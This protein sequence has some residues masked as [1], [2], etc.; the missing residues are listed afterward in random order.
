MKWRTLRIRVHPWDDEET[1]LAAI[2]EKTGVAPRFLHLEKKLESGN[3]T[4]EES[5]RVADESQKDETDMPETGDAV[6]MF[7]LAR[8]DGLNRESWQR[9]QARLLAAGHRDWAAMTWEEV[10]ARMRSEE[11][12]IDIR[13]EESR[14]RRRR[15]EELEE[16][17]S[18]EGTGAVVSGWKIEHHRLKMRVREERDLGQIFEEMEIPP[19]WVLAVFHQQF[20]RW[21]ERSVLLTKMRRDLLTRREVGVE[22]QDPQLT[23][24]SS[25]LLS[26]AREGGRGIYLFHPEL[27]SAAVVRSISSSGDNH[28][29]IEIEIDSQTL[30]EPMMTMLQIPMSR[31]MSREDVGMVGSFLI[32]DLFIEIP[33]LQDQI[34]NDPIL[35]EFF[36]VNELRRA[37]LE[38]SLPLSFTETTRSGLKIPTLKKPVD[39]MLRNLHRQTGFQ[40][41]FTLLQPI[42]EDR[43]QLFF[44][45]LQQIMGRFMEKRSRLLEEYVRYLPDL[46]VQMQKQQA[47]LIKNIKEDRPEY[48]DKYPGM[49]VRSF[50]SVICQKEH[51]PTILSAEEAARQPPERVLLFPPTPMGEFQP[52]YYY[53]PNDDYRHAGLKDMDLK[54]RNTMINLA[55]CCFNKTQDRAN[56]AKLTNIRLKSMGETEETTTPAAR[57]AKEEALRV[58]KDNI[59][60]GNLLIKYP[61]QLGELRAPSLRRLLLA[62]DPMGEYFRM[63][64]EQSPTSLLSCLL[65]HRR[66][67]GIH[68][69]FSVE[70]VRRRIAREKEYAAACLQ[71]NPGMNVEEIQRDMADPRIY[72]DPRRFYRAVELFFHV[73]LVVFFKPPEIQQEEAFL[74]EPFSARSHYA[75]R[76]SIPTLILLEHWGGKINILSRLPYPHCELLCFKSGVDA[77]LRT[78]F[79]SPFLF[80]LLEML[81]ISM[82]GL[83]RLRPLDRQQEWYLRHVVGQTPDPLGKIRILHLEVAPGRVA[84]A[85]IEPPLP[86]QDSIP[87]VATMTISEQGLPMNAEEIL[88][89]L[90]RFETWRGVDIPDSTQ[91]IVF[92]RVGAKDHVLTFPVML[93]APQ[94][95]AIRDR[96]PLLQDAIR[97]GT[98]GDLSSILMLDIPR[99]TQPTSTQ[100]EKMARCIS[101]LSLFLF[102]T[103]LHKHQLDPRGLDPDELLASF[104]KDCILFSSSV[105]TAVITDRASIGKILLRDDKKLIVPSTQF[106]ERIR[107]HLRWMLFHRPEELLRPAMLP[108]YYQKISDFTPNPHYYYFH[109]EALDVLRRNTIEERYPLHSDDLETLSIE[110]VGSTP[111]LWYRHDQ[112]PLAAPG[113]LY[114]LPNMASCLHTIAHWHRKHQIIIEDKEEDDP[115]PTMPPELSIYEWSGG[116]RS[117]RRII[118]KKGGKPYFVA[119]DGHLLLLPF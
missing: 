26:E 44:R 29:E 110:N 61:G 24:V 119:R 84:R 58:K 37:S 91:P 6:L 63:G 115:L 18:S 19:P 42:P 49:F 70:E 27:K 101:D 77:T 103:F 69:R 89:F 71:E 14:Q 41:L 8:W 21:G 38:G 2:A 68:E 20:Y 67:L 7:L 4:R 1:I 22:E 99:P 32:R 118:G 76:P 50:Y 60:H 43:I 65:A 39:V 23:M 73:R 28:T 47:S 107:Y 85:T 90:S 95:D 30:L 81:S 113:L 13:E 72:F 15:F 94:P 83:T 106:W 79:E 54:G 78:R 112:S 16:S 34:M 35:S 80:P 96:E 10:A 46:P 87:I 33:L 74:M 105:E 86:V 59:I 116:L 64:I 98:D 56:R 52:E 108:S 97:V 5:L 31:I 57:R 55:P 111:I 62:L 82:D 109:L 117:W 9:L 66:Q 102:S 45:L 48:F 93:P 25:L 53:C 100:S 3:E 114:G 92:W 75:L 104:K 51:Q 40:V 11:E 17:S 36:Y 88:P 12:R